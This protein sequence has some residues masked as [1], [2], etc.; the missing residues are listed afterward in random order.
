MMMKWKEVK[1]TG[2]WK[3]VKKEGRKERWMEGWKERKME[4]QKD[5]KEG[6]KD[7]RI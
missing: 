1:M 5:E 3:G 7:L 6:R 4:G 2:G